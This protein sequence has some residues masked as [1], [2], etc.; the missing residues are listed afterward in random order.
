MT[1]VSILTVNQPIAA[2]MT[3]P[4]AGGF[5]DDGGFLPRKPLENRRWRPRSIPAGGLLVAIR[6]GAKW[7]GPGMKPTSRPNP[8]GLAWV[9]ERWPDLPDPS[10]LATSAVVGV[11]RVRTAVRV[12]RFA[13]ETWSGPG[14]SR[15]RSPGP[16]VASRSGSR[17]RRSRRPASRRVPASS[18]P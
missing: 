10:T 12:H 15:S 9:R 5:G 16:R 1:P 7:W 8:D 11:V 3:T 2:A 18:T 6:A 4:D 13:D 14:R 17:L